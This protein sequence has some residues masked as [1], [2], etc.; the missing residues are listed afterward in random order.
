MAGD[1]GGSLADRRWHTYH[2]PTPHPGECFTNLPVALTYTYSGRVVEPTIDEFVNAKV[3]ST[4]GPL[5]LG[6]PSEKESVYHRNVPEEV[7]ELMALTHSKQF[8]LSTKSG[9]EDLATL[10]EGE[11]TPV[12]P[13]EPPKALE[14][15][16]PTGP[17][18]ELEVDEHVEEDNML[19][20]AKTETELAPGQGEIA[21][22]IERES[23]SGA[24]A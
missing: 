11:F 2:N 23:P 15:R 7:E 12:E 18:E 19:E 22:K 24:G 1:S 16:E 13:L 17:R 10:V 20:D 8:F 21:P 3:H 5:M 4:F 9:A 14:P 6:T